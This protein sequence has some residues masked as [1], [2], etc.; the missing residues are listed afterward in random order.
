[1][2]LGPERD[3]PERRGE[4]EAGEA[5]GEALGVGVAPGL[6][7]ECGDSERQVVAD[8]RA[9]ARI[10]IPL[11]AVGVDEGDVLGRLD[12]VPGIAGHQPALGRVGLER[13]EIFGLAGQQADD[14]A[15]AVEEAAVGA[16]A[17][18]LGEV[19]AEGDVVDRL[20][21][22]PGEGLDLGAGVDLEQRR[23]LLGDPGDVGAEPAHDLLEGGDRLLA[24]GVVGRDRGP[25]LRR[26]LGR[27]LGQHVGL[28]VG[29]GAEAE[30]VAVAA[31]PDERVGERLA[32]KVDLLALLGEA[33]ERQADVREE[34]AGQQGDPVAGEHLLG[35]PHRLAG[36][37]RV[38]ARDQLDR[39]AAGRRPCRSPARRRAACPCGRAR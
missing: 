39:A 11:R 33:G 35:D 1:M 23:P 25:A 10:V 20:G 32:R 37:A 3:R 12:L 31:L 24:V 7:E 30:G 6:V 27:H 18:E 36:L 22:G 14:E 21:L 16:L 17:D 26:P 28:A 5:V 15:L 38:V 29:A 34:A 9:H 19:G 2:V 4:G 8:E 13:V